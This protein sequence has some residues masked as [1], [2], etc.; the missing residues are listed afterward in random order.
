MSGNNSAYGGQSFIND[1]T[2]G[3]GANIQL[4]DWTFGFGSSGVATSALGTQL[5]IYLGEGNGG[6]LVGSST[7]TTISSFYATN[8]SVKWTFTGGLILADNVTYT[9]VVD[10]PTSFL[11]VFSGDTY[12][13]GKFTSGT[14]TSGTIDRIFSAN[15]STVSTPVPFEFETTSGLAILGG[16]WLMHQ[17]WQKK[18]AK[19]EE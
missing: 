16:A 14:T 18:A 19:K 2:G 10:S 13:N 11:Y 15:F 5:S 8:A 1:P 3:T 17:R 4:N 6:T 9:A 12:A 7:N